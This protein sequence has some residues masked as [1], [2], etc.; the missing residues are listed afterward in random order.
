M[1]KGYSKTLFF[2]F[3]V[4]YA[5]YILGVVFYTDVISIDMAS[6]WLEV[7]GFISGIFIIMTLYSHAYRKEIFNKKM[8]F[9]ILINTIACGAYSYIYTV[10]QD[11]SLMSG[12]EISFYT[13]LYL[14]IYQPIVNVI[15]ELRKQ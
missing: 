2:I 8:L 5:A 6:P 7:Y 14:L 13:F 4:L 1:R 11:F 10:W 3:A 15:L 12:L 9:F